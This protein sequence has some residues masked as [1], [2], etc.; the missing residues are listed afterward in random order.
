VRPLDTAPAAHRAYLERLARLTPEARF[1]LA[2][3]MSDDILE[4]VAQGI[5]ARAPDASDGERRELFE[6]A[7][8]GRSLA[9]SVRAA[10][11]APR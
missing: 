3:E 9:A 2:L 4:V 1:V 11:S 6:E 7:V 10:R 8:L 5:R